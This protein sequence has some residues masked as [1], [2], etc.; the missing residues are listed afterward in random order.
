MIIYHLLLF[1]IIYIIFYLINTRLLKNE[2]FYN[3]S[4][5]KSFNKVKYK[6]K[7]YDKL[8]NI[9]SNDVNNNILYLDGIDIIYWINMEES[10]DR[11]NNM[12][13]MFKDK[14]FKNIKIEK[15]NAI[16]GKKIN[17]L[18]IIETKNK[19]TQTSPSEYGCLL[20]HLEAIRK[21]SISNY[22]IALILEDDC[23]LEF[24]KYW[25]KTIK[26]IIQEAPLDWEIIK[27][28]Y[29]ADN[30]NI[31]FNWN[32]NINYFKYKNTYGTV[33][34]LINKKAAIKFIKKYYINNKYI[35][36]YHDYYVSDRFIYDKINTY[37]Y[38]YPYF[39]YRSN[40]DST[41]HSDHLILH[42]NHK[43]ILIKKYSE[44][45]LIKN[46]EHFS[47]KNKNNNNIYLYWVGNEY[48]LLKILKNLIYLHSKSGYGYN[49]NIINHNNIKMYIKD[50]PNNFYKLNYAH[51]ADYVRV[52][53][54]C[55]NGG[56]WLDSDT[57]IMGS[58]DSLFNII[59][60]KDGFF[61]KEDN[62]VLCNGIFGTKSNTFLMIEW[63]NQL[64]D[65]VNKKDKIN[66]SEIGSSMLES[67]K[68]KYPNYFNNYQIFN[69]LD[70]MYPV[71]WN[72]CV[73]EFIEKPY[74][75]YKT[76]LRSYQPLIILVNSVYKKLENLTEK[77]ILD[78]NM[79]L[80]YFINKSL[81]NIK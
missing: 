63:K 12:L 78:G 30:G 80:N 13:N 29:G 34:Y 39:I 6:L 62:K 27:L 49:V 64:N 38:K 8:N 21:F 57:I 3:K 48:N 47:N 58:L 81:G 1:I 23:T 41:L 22:N 44:I 7:L 40:N 31:I 75:N 4:Y 16:N 59:N 50:L 74:E 20:S 70:N 26:Q 19:N 10:I 46:N 69:G 42:D 9:L 2:Y 28:Y 25:N 14:I 35:L 52:N 18:S 45:K 5:Y 56:I 32:N 54:L 36:D 53:V 11:R 71:N 77:E 76:I 60:S 51:Q 66:W 15:I 73:S 24:K 67:I 37:V 65:I 79:P 33:A 43:N 61:I 55:N 17:L 68:N 72:N